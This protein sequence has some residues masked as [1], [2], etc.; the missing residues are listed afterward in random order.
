VIRVELPAH[1][2]KLAGVGGEVTV[3]VSGEATL[4]S[5]LDALESQY[6]VLQGTIRD[7]VTHRRRAFMRYFACQTDLSFD[8][9]ES[10]LPAAVA[11][12]TEPL[13]IV[14]ALAGG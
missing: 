10:P 9:P 3:E 1:L 8:A 14:G 2:R 7:H 5:V 11:A 13:L 6:P 4:R 12:G